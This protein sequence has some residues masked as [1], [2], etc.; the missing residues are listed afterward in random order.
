M[1]YIHIYIYY[2]Y[3]LHIYIPVCF[4]Q[5][6][7]Y[8]YTYKKQVCIYIYYINYIYTY[9]LHIH[10]CKRYYVSYTKVITP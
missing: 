7:G 9:Q 4:T 5:I 10:S 8:I 3:I 1:L 6:N 2:I